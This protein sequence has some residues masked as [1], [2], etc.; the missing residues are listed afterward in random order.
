MKQ[1][2]LFIMLTGLSTF[3]QPDG[4]VQTDVGQGH[5]VICKQKSKVGIWSK[6]RGEFLDPPHKGHIIHLSDPQLLLDVYPKDKKVKVYHYFQ[7][8]VQLLESV[9]DSGQFR[10]G[11]IMASQ[12]DQKLEVTDIDFRAKKE[13]GDRAVLLCADPKDPLNYNFGSS[14]EYIFNQNLLKIAFWHENT[15]DDG[16]TISVKSV[17]YPDEDSIDARGYVVY[18]PKDEKSIYNSGVLN[19]KTGKWEIQPRYAGINEWE[20][21]YGA[22]FWPPSEDFDNKKY[23]WGT[24]VFDFYKFIPKAGIQ[25]TAFTDYQKFAFPL[26]LWPFEDEEV[27]YDHD[28][29]YV[30]HKNKKGIGMYQIPLRGKYYSGLNGLYTLDWY[31]SEGQFEVQELLPAK[32]NYIVMGGNLDHRSSP[33]DYKKYYI[34]ANKGQNEFDILFK[35]TEREADGLSEDTLIENV[36]IDK[37]IEFLPASVWKSP[38]TK[39]DKEEWIGFIDHKNVVRPHPINGEL[40]SSVHF[41]P[42]YLNEREGPEFYYKSKHIG[43]NKMV[44]FSYEYE[45]MRDYVPLR[46]EVDPYLDSFNTEGQQLYYAPEPGKYYTGLFDGNTS[47]WIV[48]PKVI[49]IYPGNGGYVIER[50]VLNENLNLQAVVFDF[51]Q[52]DGTYGFRDLSSKEFERPA[53]KK[54][55]IYNYTPLEVYNVDPSNDHIVYFKT[56]EGIGLA[57]LSAHTGKIMKTPTEMLYYQNDCKGI[58]ALDG[59]TLDLTIY[60]TIDKTWRRNNIRVP[61]EKGTGIQVF[62]YLDENDSEKWYEFYGSSYNSLQFVHFTPDTATWYAMKKDTAVSYA[63]FYEIEQSENFKSYNYEEDFGRN[64]IGHEVLNWEFKVEAFTDE[65]IYFQHNESPGDWIPLMSV[66][67]WGIDSLDSNGN[68]VFEP[69]A[70]G[71]THSGV[72]NRSTKTWEIPNQY[73]SIEHISGHIYLLEQLTW[74]KKGRGRETKYI[75]HQDGKERELYASASSEFDHFSVGKISDSLLF[76]NE[77]NFERIEHLAEESLLYPGV[78]SIDAYGN[79]VYYPAKPGQYKSG[80]YNVYTNEWLVPNKQMH[81]FAFDTLFIV[82]IA[83]VNEEGFI[84][85]VQFDQYDLSGNKLNPEPISAN[86]VDERHREKVKNVLGL[87]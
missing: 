66:Y 33:N 3:A 34:L 48:E 16:N 31:A 53:Y 63:T 5:V 70:P 18:Y 36:V 39:S 76:I 11:H 47:K 58:L 72:W 55:K 41:T 64:G 81:V 44:V 46:S 9:S 65:L 32:Y 79:V 83:V 74:D 2:S 61:I 7:G 62:G 15:N 60:N 43:N 54:Y 49:A 1:L 20:G 4:W 86:Q 17:L 29:I 37:F 26:E 50:P 21:I 42:L 57:S 56:E 75:L 77:G 30:Y 71:F 82:A 59:D 10:L 45:D 68:P 40:D 80:V 24:W 85:T 38:T 27:W 8:G 12:W 13:S 67:D 35:V 78:D 73:R 19:I 25:P 28:S 51:L 23:T 84:E 52:A 6:A 69:G 87:F 14:F 22:Y